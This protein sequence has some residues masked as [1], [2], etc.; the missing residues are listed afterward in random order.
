MLNYQQ[1]VKDLEKLYSTNLKSGLTEK[2]VQESRKKYW[3]NKIQ[4]KNKINPW[5]I[6]FEQFKS[7]LILILLFAIVI[8]AVMWEWVDAIVIIVIVILNAI[9][10]FVQEYNA[11]KS[12]ES[13]KKMSAL[14]AKVIR[15]WKELLI[16]SSEL[17]VW[18]LILFEAWDKIWADARLIQAMN[19]E[20]AEAVLTWESVPVAKNIDTINEIVPLWDQCN[21]VFSGTEITKGRWMAIVTNVWMDS[22][23]WKIA[24]MLQEAPEKQTHLQRDLDALS[25]KLW[26]IILII[27]IIIFLVDAF[28]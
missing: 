20:V 24:W 22:E 6:F 3:E 10:W 2:W 16:D 15:W 11:E 23:I 8:S 28:I 14:K 25:K 26:V 4:S 1:N 13:L 5:K 27:C 9:L 21:M 19:T 7:F 12:I 18:D 17:V